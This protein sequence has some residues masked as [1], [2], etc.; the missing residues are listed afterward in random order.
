MQGTILST[1]V[2]AIYQEFLRASAVFPNITYDVLD[3]SQP[4]FLTDLGK[5]R[6]IIRDLEERLGY[7]G[8]LL[9]WTGDRT[10]LM[11]LGLCVCAECLYVVIVQSDHCA[12]L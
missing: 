7:G 4:A 6:A 8:C 11:R 2:Q 5:F 12:G 9:G 3:V 10:V 1:Q